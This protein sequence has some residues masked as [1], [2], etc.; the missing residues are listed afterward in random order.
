MT[1]HPDPNTHNPSNTQ[2][3]ILWQVQN[4]IHSSA[5]LVRFKMGSV[6]VV[7]LGR[8]TQCHQL[9]KIARE[10]FNAS[11]RGAEKGWEGMVRGHQLPPW[12]W[13]RWRGWHWE[14]T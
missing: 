4:K 6:S 7:N 8:V 12:W 11:Q 14:N 5:F 13:G 10:A 2:C 1:D 3:H 9:T